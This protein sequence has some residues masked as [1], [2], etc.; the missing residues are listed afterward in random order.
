MIKQ[1]IDNISEDAI[2]S[3]FRRKITGYQI[4]KDEL[5]YIMPDNGYEKFTDLNKLGEWTYE[6]SDE[7]LVFSCKYEGELTAR[8][9]KKKQYDLAKKVLKED[10]K[11]GAIFIFYDQSG[12]FR[13]SLLE[14]IMMMHL[15]S[16]HHS[17]D[18]LISFN[19]KNIT[20]HFKE[21]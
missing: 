3:F 2:N 13:F 14:E 9:S 7:L 17:S 18:I 5:D 10:F 21:E 6:N 15:L 20:K 19:Q 1:L 12:K 8:S 11:D 4:D 16:I